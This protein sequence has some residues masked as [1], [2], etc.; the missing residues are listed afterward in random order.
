M[1]DPCAERLLQGS[2]HQFGSYSLPTVVLVKRAG[3]SVGS[4]ARCFE[5][6]NPV[7]CCGLSNDIEIIYYCSNSLITK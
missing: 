1:Q 7:S 4:S 2:L 5:S 3:T 6:A